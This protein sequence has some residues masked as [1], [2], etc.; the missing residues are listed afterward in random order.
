MTSTIPSLVRDA[1][2]DFP[3]SLGDYYRTSG[4]L[5]DNAPINYQRVWSYAGALYGLV[6]EYG[7]WT[8]QAAGL[9]YFKRSWH[10]QRST[11]G[12]I[13]WAACDDSN[14]PMG[15]DYGRSAYGEAAVQIGSKI[16][17]F[18]DYGDHPTS[19][20]Y[21]YDEIRAQAFDCTTNTWGSV[22]TGGPIRDLTSGSDNFINNVAADC[23]Y[24][25]SDEVVVFHYDTDETASPQR[26]MY[27]IFNTSSG[28]WSALNTVVFT[29]ATS[30][31]VYPER[32]HYDGSV[33]RFIAEA[34]A[35]ATAGTGSR[36]HRTLS[37][38]TL[39]TVTD[40][41]ASWPGGWR[42]LTA[43]FQNYYGFTAIFGG[44]FFFVQP[45]WLFTAF[46]PTK[47]YRL[48]A[49]RCSVGASAPSWTPEDI[50]STAWDAPYVSF[51]DSGAPM[52]VQ[53]AGDLYCVAGGFGT[54][55]GPANN[56]YSVWAQRY[57]GSGAWDAPTELWS[58]LDAYGSGYGGPYQQN[59]ILKCSAV[60][61]L[62][63]ADLNMQIGWIGN[64]SWAPD[65]KD[66]PRFWRGPVPSC[67][68]ANYAY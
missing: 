29:S 56:R 32:C 20:G 9:Y 5:N 60:G 63:G 22:I 25:G 7:G 19:H 12:G 55:T 35:Y 41:F 8:G 67:C 59:E 64:I 49:F 38:S 1:Y 37:G 51:G 58:E 2:P 42:A 10:M 27:S 45:A 68:C 16:W 34:A 3:T 43:D 17:V 14:R 54:Y 36:W 31:H 21:Q 6:W 40:M 28:T 15:G 57:A 61:G 53:N 62:T 18:F 4:R 30:S 48:I 13:T 39:G 24:R 47:Q 26:A 66:T 33:V 46:P 23:C 65:S 44:E 52:L 50:G 11:D